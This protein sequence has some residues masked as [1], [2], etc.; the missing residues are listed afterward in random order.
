MNALVGTWRFVEV[1]DRHA[2]DDPKRYDFGEHPLGYIVYDDTGHIFVQIATADGAW[3]YFGTYTID[4]ARGLVI[5]HVIADSR[6]EFTGTDQE[7]PFRLNGDELVIGD[8]KT[9]LSR[10]MR[11]RRV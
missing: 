9:W 5:H 8:G 3:A 7:R 11:E 2:P 1:W 4:A 10:L 6:R